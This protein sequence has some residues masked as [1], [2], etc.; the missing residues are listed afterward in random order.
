MK[1]NRYVTQSAVVLGLFA[2][3]TV[4]QVL[5]HADEANTSVATT[6]TESVTDSGTSVVSGQGTSETAVQGGAETVSA[7]PT[8][9]AAN[10]SAEPSS[11]TSTSQAN[12]EASAVLT[13]ANQVTPAVPV[14]AEPV[15]EPAHEGQTV[16]MQI[17]S[18]TDL[19][20]NLVNYDYYQDKP[21]QTVGLSKTAV[22]I[23]KSRETN[24]NTVLVDSGD[25]IQRTPFGTYKALIDPVAQGETHPMYK[26]FEML[27]YDAET[28]GNHEF[29][30]GLEFL[31]RMVKAAKINIINANVRNAQTG[32]YYY[33]PYKIVNKTF[34]DRDGKQIALKIGITG[35]L[36]T[37]IL[38]WD[39]ANLEGKVTVD[40]PMEA[41][42]TIVPQMKAAGA[43][44]ILV[45]THSSIGDNE[46]T[47]NEENKGYQIAGIEGVDALRQGILM[48]ISQMVMAQVFMLNIL[49]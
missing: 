36:P 20:T 14:Q 1:T 49:V 28:L 35:V 34:T 17:L 31:D 5:G 26:A 7:T 25:T 9:V 15:T 2:L 24:P 12:Q 40:D 13:N 6:S 46:Y 16:D 23:K 11:N 8:P 3:L 29:N 21:S 37:Q 41:V 43:D 32:D 10:A 38:A 22:L 45:A 44:F 33:N 48:R 4:P 27:G 47:K 30:Y 19:H 18:T 42:K 39:K